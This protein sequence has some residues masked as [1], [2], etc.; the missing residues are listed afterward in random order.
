MSFWIQN[1]S[2]LFNSN[3]IT[4]IWPYSYMNKDSKFN[5]ITRFVILLSLFGYMCINRII[6]LILG[7]IIIGLI[8]LLYNNNKEGYLSSYFKEYKKDE[9]NIIENN[10]FNNVLMT[11]YKYNSEKKED[12]PVNEYT[13]EVE[14][15]LNETIKNSILEQNK[16]NTDMIYM[17]SDDKHNFE[18]EQNMRQ[19]NSNPS[20]TIPNGQDKFLNF[21]YGTLYSE[22]PLT[23]Y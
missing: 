8:V 5:A 9:I 16:D 18:F 20:T 3:Y 7:I 15:K 19:F 13:P 23:I 14:N 21:C 11:D 4:Q 17:F 2:I 22:K 6:I 1:P 12:Q 10:P